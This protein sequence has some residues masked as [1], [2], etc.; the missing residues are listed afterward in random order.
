M[1]NPKLRLFLLD[2]YLKNEAVLHKSIGPLLGFNISLPHKRQILS[3]ELDD[4]SCYNCMA[5][6]LETENISL[7]IHA[8]KNYYT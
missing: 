4:I 8:V 2:Q 3:L 6:A 1:M 7:N 5:Y